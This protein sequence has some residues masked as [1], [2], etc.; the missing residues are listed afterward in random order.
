MRVRYITTCALGLAAA[1]TVAASTLAAQQ[2]QDTTKLRRSTTSSTRIPISK[3]SPGEVVT[4]RVDTVY[5]T[6]YDTVTNTITRVDTVTV[7][8]PAPLV[9]SRVKGP[10]YWGLFGGSTRP[11]GN[12]D[13]VYTNGFHAGGVLGWES[14]HAP[15]GVRLDGQV[16]QLGREETLYRGTTL[17]STNIGSGTPLFMSL[18]GDVKVA[19]LNF[20]GW[21]LYGIGGLNVNRYRAIAMASQD[22]ADFNLRGSN[23]QNAE[24]DWKTK[25]G[26]NFGTG[27]D[28]HIGSQDMFLEYRWL[29]NRSEGA[30]SYINPISIGVRYF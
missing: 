19:P 26:F 7:T 30:N 17:T 23:Y 29:A 18:A 21:K 2:T 5:V 1:L 25:W 24:M 16:S 6:R 9:I 8:P 27:L 4:T 10:M 3:E 20:R 28:F 14:Q 15:I 13:R 11:Y 12:I 22:V